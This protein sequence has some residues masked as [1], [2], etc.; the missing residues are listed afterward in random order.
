M[1]WPMVREVHLGG[2][3]GSSQSPDQPRRMMLFACKTILFPIS[4]IHW[5]I[6]T[7]STSSF[8]SISGLTTS[9]KSLT[10]SRNRIGPQTVPWGTP[11]MTGV[12]SEIA[13]PTLTR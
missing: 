6:V 1:A 4:S 2:C 7:S 5:A 8:K 11:E 12:A 10:K 3:T 9:G 13:D